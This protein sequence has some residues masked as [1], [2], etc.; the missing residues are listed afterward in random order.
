MNFK[1]IAKSIAISGAVLG[2][3]YTIR[4]LGYAKLPKS[5]MVTVL[6]AVD[7]NQ[8]GIPDYIA[9]TVPSRWGPITYTREPTR[10]E[11]D[12]YKEYSKGL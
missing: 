2:T 12:W 1:N 6:E 10:E 9:V 5:D 7:R 8:D 3:L 4:P 11:T